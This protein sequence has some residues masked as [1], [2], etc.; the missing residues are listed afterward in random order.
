MAF[1]QETRSARE[2]FL[3]AP[4]A[5]FALIAVIVAAHVARVLLPETVS[6]Q[7]LEAGALIPARFDAALWAQ[8]GNPPVSLWDALLPFLGYQFLHADFL[9]LGVNCLWLLVAGTPV[10][11][12]LSAARF[13]ALYLVSGVVAGLVFLAA[14]LGTISAAIGASGAV[15]GMMGAAIRIFYGERGFAAGPP[16]A[17]DDAGPI[18]PPLAGLFSGPIVFFTVIWC[19]TNVL[20]GITGLGTSGNMQAVAWEAHLGG[21]FAGLILV[22]LFDGRSRGAV[23]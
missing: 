20:A 19:I 8:T 1:F 9:H 4:L 12:R 2:P 17:N 5:V 6:D 10:A 11:R 18:R 16:A 3:R 13:L 14:N 7:V 22:G 21:Y 23:S 15:S